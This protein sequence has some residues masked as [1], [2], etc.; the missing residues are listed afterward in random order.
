[1]TWVTLLFALEV[2]L[3][4]STGWLMHEDAVILPGTMY[5]T[6]FDAEVE[7]FDL[8]FIGGSVRTTMGKSELSRTFV[9]NFDEY[10]FQAGIR[11]E[12]LEVGFRHMCT[13]PVFVYIGERPQ[14]TVEYEGWYQEVYIRIGG[15][16]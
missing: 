10:L 5:Y 12:P 13:H 4:P 16:L 9:P 14:Y 7:M 1:M 15:E 2:G 8:L 11:L 3:V 6:E